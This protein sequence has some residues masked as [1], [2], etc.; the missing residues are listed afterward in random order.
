MTPRYY[1]GG[2]STEGGFAM[3]KDFWRAAASLAL[4]AAAMAGARA[5]TTDELYAKAKA[6]GALSLYGGGPAAPWENAAARF[7]AKYP[8]IDVKIEA[9]FS[10]VFDQKIDQQIAAHKMEVDGAILQTIQDFV[11]WNKEGQL[12][13]FKPEGFDKIDRNWKDKDGAYVGL[14]VNAHPYAYNTALVKP[15]DVPKSARDFLKPEWKGKLVSAYP[16]D[17]D[18]T[19]YD[20]NSIT[21][22]YGWSYWTKYMANAPKFIQGHLGVARSISAGDT[23]VSLDTI[24]S[25]SLA[26]KAAG[27]PQD[28]AFSPVDPVPI[29]AVTAGVF[30]GAPH[31]NAAKLFIAWELSKEVQ[32]SLPP[33]TWPV[34]SDVPPGAGLKP[35]LSYKV[36]NSYREFLTKTDLPALRARF[37]KLVG[38]ITNKGGVQ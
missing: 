25:I 12:L 13:R 27:K 19:L 26:E 16:Q 37:V 38:P 9:G 7:K 2:R 29:W 5:E 24:A 20:F 3:Q 1:R 8:G 36:V 17:D 35:I 28:I 11:R 14:S 21:R 32:A 34:R 33:G 10:N 6:E 15:A 31:P 23:L 22:K 30:K 4:L 18:A